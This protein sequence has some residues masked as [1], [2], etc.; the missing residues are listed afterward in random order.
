MH[1][2]NTPQ[3]LLE[4]DTHTHTV[5]S[6]H[7]FSTI[8]ELAQ[9]A[10]KKGLKGIAVTDHGPAIPDGAHEWH[11][12]SMRTLPPYIEGVRVL[13]GVE[14]N[15]MDYEGTLDIRERYQEEL[16]WVIASYHDPC[17]DP[18]TV[19]QHTAS[20]LKVAEN[21]HVDVIGHSGTGSYRYD[22]EKV[23]PVFKAKGKLVEINSHSFSTR[24]GAKDNC[25]NIALL[26]KKYEAPIVV[27]SDAHS[28][29]VV[30]D[31]QDAMSM[32]SDIGFPSELIIN[33]TLESLADW[34]FKKRGRKIL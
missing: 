26:C 28:C 9:Y 8:L 29:F 27:N 23:I 25:R 18:G 6:T 16:D 31:L 12:G 1:T 30:G 13:H 15:I 20:Y 7:A 34:I 21:P 19:E 11:F 5:A 10:A 2:E 22:Y 17:C 24:K 3:A 14:A 32:L 4:T 33:R